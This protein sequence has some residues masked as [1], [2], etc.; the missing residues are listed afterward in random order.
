MKIRSS[1]DNREKN[2]NG[3]KFESTDVNAG[4]KKTFV[5]SELY[6]K[7]AVDFLALHNVTEDWELKNAAPNIVRRPSLLK[8]PA[9]NLQ[10]ACKENKRQILRQP[11]GR[12]SPTTKT[13]NSL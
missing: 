10:Q 8:I 11:G 1:T 7:V 3:M 9:A 12:V 6:R 2:C 13:K 4:F 5:L